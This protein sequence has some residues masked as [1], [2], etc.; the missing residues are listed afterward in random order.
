MFQSLDFQPNIKYW[1]SNYNTFQSL[2]LSQKALTIGVQR[3][4]S[5][6][7]D[8]AMAAIPIRDPL[9]LISGLLIHR[10]QKDNP[11]IKAFCEFYTTHSR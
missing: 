9:T 6:L 1:V 3:K 4:S 2:L 5:Q 10:S 7:T 11:V 8:P